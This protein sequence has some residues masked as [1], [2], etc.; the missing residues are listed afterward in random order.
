MK[1]DIK[2]QINIKNLYLSNNDL[3]NEEFIDHIREETKIAISKTMIEL[4]RFSFEDISLS[5]GLDIERVKQ[6]V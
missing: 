1:E 2:Y 6:L 5:T 4:S 3:M